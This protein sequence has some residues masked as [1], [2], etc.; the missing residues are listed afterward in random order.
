MAALG[1]I[2]LAGFTVTYWKYTWR[3]E[4]PNGEIVWGNSYQELSEK[5]VQKVVASLEV[6]F[7]AG[8]K[9]QC[10]LIKKMLQ[11]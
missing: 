3:A 11:I 4:L 6:V 2:H 1:S 7:N 8:K 10:N 9:E 5:E